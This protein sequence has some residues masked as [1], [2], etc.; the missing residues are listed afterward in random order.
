[1]TALADQSTISPWPAWVILGLVA[2]LLLAVVAACLPAAGRQMPTPNAAPPGV[3]LHTPAA[4]ATNPDCAQ[5][6]HAIS[7][8]GD[9]VWICWR[10]GCLETWLAVP[11]NRAPFD[12]ERHA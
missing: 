2:L 6:G 5:R 10:T 8:L 11:D 12:Q 4:R 7:R 9:S 1:M 3:T